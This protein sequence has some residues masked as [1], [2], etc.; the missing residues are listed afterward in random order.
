MTRISLSPR[1]VGLLCAAAAQCLV[2][3]STGVSS[4]LSGYPPAAGQM[5][6]YSLA[7]AVLFAVLRI[8]R[9]R[10]LMPTLR[11]LALLALL[12]LAG[13][14]LYTLF[15]LSAV[16]HADPAT[17]GSVIGAGPLLL[18]VAAPLLA[19]RS[20]TAPV[21]CAAAL[22][23][24]GAMV[25]QG[26]GHA[27][28][29]GLALAGGVALCEVGVPL[30]AAPLLPRLGPLRVAAY[31]TVMAVV[32]MFLLGLVTGKATA[33]PALSAAETSALLYLALALTAGAFLL[34]FTA[35]TRISAETAGLFVGLVPVSAAFS[36][37]VL[38]QGSL[39]ASQFAGTLLV[40]AG[41]AVGIRRQRP[42]KPSTTL[43]SPVPLTP[44][45]PLPA[46]AN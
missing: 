6:R 15:L 16:Q 42:P 22:V 29:L 2:G 21:V 27:T 18:A 30:I 17:V 19:R 5:L 34:W 32:Q 13:Q 44:L 40:G 23:T 25:V 28:G 7:A 3:A 45:V 20:P 24:A 46:E 39:T 11:E 41:V 4:V 33:I 9:V 1:T 8:R 37:L 36:G 12:A 31:S 38:A 26:F 43:V 14:S 35:L 10:F